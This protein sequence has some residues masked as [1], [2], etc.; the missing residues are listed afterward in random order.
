MGRKIYFCENIKII[1]GMT[2]ST[3]DNLNEFIKA[4]EEGNLAQITSLIKDQGINVNGKNEYGETALIYASE[5]GHL[6]IV[7][8]LVDNGADVNE[9][10]H[11][12]QTVLMYASYITDCP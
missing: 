7:K 3:R 8:Y 12:L 11:Q 5:K 4:A 6:D 10:G 1:P 9:K 2:S